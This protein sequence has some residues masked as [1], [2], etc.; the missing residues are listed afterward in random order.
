MLRLTATTK[1]RV[2]WILVCPRPGAVTRP[3]TAMME[4]PALSTRQTTG[5]LAAVLGRFAIVMMVRL[6]PLMLVTTS[7]GA[8]ILFGRIVMTAM[9]AQSILAQTS[10]AVL[11]LTSTAMM[12]MLAPSISATR[13][14]VANTFLSTVTPAMP[15]KRSPVFP[16]PVARS[17]F[18]TVMIPPLVL[19]IRA[20]VPR[21][22]LIGC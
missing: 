5:P 7:L 19:G 8:P 6:A 1:R 20:I 12:E 13:Q 10:Q 16:R 15:A 11:G 22:A 14:L 2:Q 4:M 3:S 17:L 18:A 21:D 9:L